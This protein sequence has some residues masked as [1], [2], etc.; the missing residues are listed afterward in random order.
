[1]C[2]VL[3]ACRFWCHEDDAPAPARR[4]YRG[5]TLACRRKTGDRLLGRL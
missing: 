4:A 1:M 2:W 5:T 3:A